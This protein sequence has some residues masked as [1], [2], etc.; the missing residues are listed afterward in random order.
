MITNDARCT[1]EIKPRIFMT[2][3][4]FTKNTLSTSKIELIL[5]KKPFKYCTWNTNLYGA[6]IG[7]LGKPIRNTLKVLKCGAGE[8][9]R[10]SF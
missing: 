4:A 6:E 5:R 2:K 1:R 9:R 7:H 8:G 3:A 10:R